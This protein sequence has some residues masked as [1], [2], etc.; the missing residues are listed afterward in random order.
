MPVN[1]HLQ[2]LEITD[3]SPGLWENADW[4]M[5]ASGAQEMIDCYPQPGGGLRAFF[6]A[7]SLSVSGVA[8]ITKERVIGVYS[9]SGSAG[10]DRYLMTYVFDSGAGSGTKARPK[11]YRMNVSESTWTQI[12]VN[13]GTTQFNFASSD[14]NSP[15]RAGFRR[16]RLS[17]G[18][19]YV[20]LVARYVGT[21]DGAGAGLY[22]LNQAD[23][24]SAQK[25]VDTRLLNNTVRPWGAIALHQAR[26]IVVLSPDSERLCWTDVAAIT[27][28]AANFLDVEPSQDLVDISAM[29][30]LE[31]SDL[32]ILKEGSPHVVIQGDITSPTVQSM[33]EGIN[34]G[35]SGIQDLGR[36][37]DGMAFI[38][39]DG[40]IYLTNGYTFDNI[41]QQLNGFTL[42]TLAPS[43]HLGDLN[44]VNQF[45]FGP[46]GYVYDAATKSWFKQTQIT[47]GFH[48]IDR[49][50][51]KLWGNS[52]NST[53]FTL[54][55][56][57][58]YPG[59]SRLSTYSWKSAPL[60]SPDGRQLEIREVEVVAKPY[61]ASATIA[62]TVNGTTVT[63]TLDGSSTKQDRSFLFKQ[64]AEVL[65][66][67]VVATAGSA[68]NEAPSI[69]TVRIYTRSGHQTY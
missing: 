39:A 27:S 63:K 38:N 45:L 15:L 29:H 44:F 61:D 32:L 52:G 9:A 43:V 49:Y 60:R 16:F 14:N 22:R 25:A 65:D 68:A 50:N 28:A 10:V 40:Y 37:P 56:L 69:E 4:L 34:P 26:V 5:P 24:S 57:K 46:Q 21:Q 41:S 67:R 66:V 47:G 53:S 36:T 23:S 7:T 35:G 19:A 20:M 8:D 64:R 55:E 59:Q 12:F 11:L 54:S 3:F 51:R 18:T 62:V 33:S 6:K 58:P 13:S 31:P 1:T 48:Y 30:P 42:D 17:D 2:V